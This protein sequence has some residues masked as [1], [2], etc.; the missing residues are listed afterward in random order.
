MSDTVQL[1]HPNSGELR[2][3]EG[4]DG[5]DAKRNRQY[6]YMQGWKRID[7]L[8]CNPAQKCEATRSYGH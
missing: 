7:R 5:E 2:E 1:F 8:R 3:V 6:L 4:G